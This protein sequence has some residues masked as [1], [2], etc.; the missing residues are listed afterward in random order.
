V[1]KHATGAAALRDETFIGGCLPEPDVVA[2]KNG[3]G[4]PPGLVD[5]HDAITNIVN[6]MSA[7]ASAWL[8]V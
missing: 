5:S 8:R 4:S 2:R 3:V 1:A 7:G 6:T